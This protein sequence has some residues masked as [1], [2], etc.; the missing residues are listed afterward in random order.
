MIHVH[1][2]FVCI[3]YVLRVYHYSACHEILDENDV[4]LEKVCKL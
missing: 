2:N 4:M 3:V 1:I